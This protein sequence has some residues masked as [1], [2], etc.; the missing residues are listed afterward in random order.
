MNRKTNGTTKKETKVKKFCNKS[1]AAQYNNRNRARINLI[2]DE[3]LINA[4]SQ[5]SSISEFAEKIGYS[6]EM[7]REDYIAKRLN[8]L[9]INLNDLKQRTK[10]R[11]FSTY[12]KGE[13]FALRKSWQS[14][15]SSIARLAREIYQKSNKPKY[16]IV[17]G[18]PHYEVAH[19]KAV[20]DFSNDVLISEINSID[21]LIGLCPNHHYEYDNGILSKEEL[22]N[23]IED[24]YHNN[25]GY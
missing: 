13:A 21:N 6:T 12:T 23:A 3:E 18:Y 9:K 17:C 5:S 7:L 16:C 24:N 10:D 2:S 11:M 25:M 20:S 15:R 4:F 1:C 19:I 14:V 8:K 22:L